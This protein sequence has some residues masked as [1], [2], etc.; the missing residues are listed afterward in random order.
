VLEELRGVSDFVL[1]LVATIVFLR[2]NG[3]PDS[4]E[5]EVAVRKPLKATPERL[6]R[7][8]RLIGELGL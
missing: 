4:A 8:R 3:Y 7:A 6:E 5:Q 2:R 1:E